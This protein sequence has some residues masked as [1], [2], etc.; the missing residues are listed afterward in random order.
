MTK[1]RKKNVKPNITKK[2]EIDYPVFCFKHLQDV[3]IKNCNDHKF[4]NDFI[5]RLSKLGSLTW[6]QI[7]HTDKHS[8]GT[9][10][11]PISQIKPKLPNFISPDVRDLLVFR[12]S[13]NNRSFL[14]V[15][16]GNVFHIIFIETKFGDIYKH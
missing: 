10:K 7:I 1:I 3:S 9:E 4:L 8:F 15:R 2:Q 6:N 14:G 12:A 13:G 11:I 5:F 16:S